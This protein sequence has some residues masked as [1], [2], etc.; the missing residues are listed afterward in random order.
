MLGE[1]LSNRLVEGTVK[2]GGGSVMLWDCMTWKWIGFAYGIEGKMGADIM[3]RS[4]RRS[5]SK[6]LDCLTNLKRTLS[7]SKIMIPSILAERPRSGLK[8][9]S[10]RSWY[11]L[12]N[13]QTSTL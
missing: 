10:L 7:F 1:G 9:M 5:F 12:L 2:F 8:T 13:L 6:P 3:F 11:G 4:W